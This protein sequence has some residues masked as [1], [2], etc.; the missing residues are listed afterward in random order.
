M[1]EVISTLRGVSRE[2]EGLAAVRDQMRTRDRVMMMLGPYMFSV[3]TATPEKLT[4]SASYDWP[5]QD[6]VGA[7]PLL[8]WTGIGS[9][10]ISINGVIYPAYKGGLG[11][12]AALREMAG[13]GKRW[14]LVDGRGVVYGKYVLRQV[15]ESGTVY[16]ANGMPRRIDFGLTLD[17]AGD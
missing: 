1:A 4:H 9:E 7:R 16:D 13:M 8:Q 15:E 14:L 11:Q 10:N 17:Y 12:M 2:R 6:R 3:A 5:S